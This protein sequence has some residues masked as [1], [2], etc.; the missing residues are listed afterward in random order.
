MFKEWTEKTLKKCDRQ[1]SNRLFNIERQVKE[2]RFI[3]RLS[4][5][6]SMDLIAIMKDVCFKIVLP[7]NLKSVQT[8]YQF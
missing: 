1:Q 4:V 8:I 5:N 7:P 2:G 6:Y 3:Y